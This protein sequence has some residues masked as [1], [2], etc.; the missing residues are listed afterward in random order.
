M[1]AAGNLFDVTLDTAGT[2]ALVL[3]VTG[4]APTISL[5]LSNALVDCA[6]ADSGEAAPFAIAGSG[7]LYVRG[8]HSGWNAQEAYRLR[9]KGNNLYQAVADFNGE[10]EF[11][12]AS[13]DGSWTTQ[14]WVQDGSG[15][16]IRR[17]L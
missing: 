3:D 7:Q 8:S 5:T 12:L 6:V 2:Y 17:G 16:R 11:K 14:L 9:Y 13:D 10:F 1:T 4:S 15:H